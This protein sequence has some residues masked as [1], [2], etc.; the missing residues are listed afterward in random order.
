M[1]RSV[2]GAEFR[3]ALERSSASP[4]FIEQL[5]RFEPFDRLIDQDAA[6]HDG[7]LATDGVFRAPALCTLVTGNLTAG[8]IDL[9][10]GFDAG[11]LFIVLGDVACHHFIGHYGVQCFIDGDLTAKESILTGFEDSSMN[12]IGTLRTRLFVGADIICE[13]GCGADIDYGVGCCAPLGYEHTGEPF[14]LPRYDE[15]AAARIVAVAHEPTGFALD[16]EK[17]ADLVRS[18]LPLFR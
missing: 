14:I 6:I 9:S 2:T 8:I 11:G 17:C 10:A 13:V 12:V 1:A 3:Q 4:S 16:V 18:G 7:N 5:A 15:T